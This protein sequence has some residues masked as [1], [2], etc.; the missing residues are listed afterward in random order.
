M[1]AAAPAEQRGRGAAI[2]STSCF[3][4]SAPVLLKPRAQPDSVAAQGTRSPG[5]SLCG[6]PGSVSRLGGQRGSSRSWK[7]SKSRIFSW[8]C[9]SRSPVSLPQPLCLQTVSILCRASKNDVLNT[10]R[11]EALNQ[12][13]SFL[14]LQA[15]ESSA[16]LEDC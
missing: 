5:V 3:P 13:N 10:A 11:A 15:F 1:R 7:S 16:L 8:S 2:R 4:S 12:I 9:A 6:S 14:I